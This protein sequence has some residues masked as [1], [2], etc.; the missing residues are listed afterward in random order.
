M[1]IKVSCPHCD[2]SYTVPDAKEGKNVRCRNCDEKIVVGRGRRS[3]REEDDYEEDDRPRRRSRS[4]G[5]PAW[6]WVLGGGGVAVVFVVVLLLALTSK[7]DKGGS[8]GIKAP[9]K[10]N[11]GEARNPGAKPGG[12]T[13]GEGQVA[14]VP[15]TAENFRRLRYGMSEAEVSAV[16]GK[17]TSR[18][19]LPDGT[20][21]L[22]W[23]RR[24]DPFL[25]VTLNPQNRLSEARMWSATAV[26][27]ELPMRRR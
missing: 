25:I 7:G 27:G 12:S 21:V 4:G 26:F 17:P 13:P 15:L 1:G 6:A 5:I 2:E 8:G 20:R 3:A 14:P 11:T 9:P 19:E 23:E 24:G 10:G 16:F 22:S 18:L